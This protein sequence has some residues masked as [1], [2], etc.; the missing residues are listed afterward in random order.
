L[1]SKVNDIWTN[2][3]SIHVKPI[4]EANTNVLY[5]RYFAVTYCTSYL[6]KVNKYVT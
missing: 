4:W 6:T 5:N 1:K 2:V 3:F